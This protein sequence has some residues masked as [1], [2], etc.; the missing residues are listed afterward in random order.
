MWLR[1]LTRH[2]WVLTSVHIGLIGLLLLALCELRWLTRATLRGASRDQFSWVPF[3]RTW[4]YYRWGAIGASAVGVLWAISY[5]GIEGVTFDDR[6]P[7]APLEMRRAVA[8]VTSLFTAD[9]YQAELW[10]R[11]NNWGAT[12]AELASAKVVS[13]ERRDFRGAVLVSAFLVKANLR[14]AQLEQAYLANAQLQGADLAGAQLQGANLGGAQLQRASIFAADLTWTNLEHADLGQADLRGA[15]LRGAIL[16][17]ATLSEADLCYANLSWAD[18]TGADLGQAD[19]SNVNLSNAHLSRANLRGANLS[20]TPLGRTRYDSI[21]RSGGSGADLT[22]TDLTEARGLT[23]DQIRVAK[24]DK[25][26]KLPNALH[27]EAR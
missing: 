2:D 10:P 16:R 23:C 25:T 14:W 19:L 3:W 24:T 21:F 9:L 17:E 15:N 7:T 26:T 18:L 6:Y 22:N 4:R 5:A 13:L 11:P 27:C 20:G 8:R 1:Y 12:K